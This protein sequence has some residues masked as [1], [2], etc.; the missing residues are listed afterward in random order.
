[1]ALACQAVAAHAVACGL[2]FPAVLA[3]STRPHR[4]PAAI[5]DGV[6]QLLCCSVVENQGWH[7]LALKAPWFPEVHGFSVH[8]PQQHDVAC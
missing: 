1:M 8:H 3:A 4:Q 6:Y 5:R 7:T 2:E